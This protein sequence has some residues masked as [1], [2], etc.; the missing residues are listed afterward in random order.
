MS[1][2]QQVISQTQPALSV[3]DRIGAEPD[4][5]LK[6]LLNQKVMT[7]EL[8]PEN[9]DK[10]RNELIEELKRNEESEQD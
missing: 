6:E 9:Y 10:I 2:N 8:T 5:G 7:C 3:E 4:E 1:M